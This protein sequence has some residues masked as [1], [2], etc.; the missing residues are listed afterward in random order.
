MSD[1]S[2]LSQAAVI[3]TRAR[4][5]SSKALPRA[6]AE[7]LPAQQEKTEGGDAGDAADGT[8]VLLDA[9]AAY[10]A[11]H[12]ATIPSVPSS[13]ARDTG[14]PTSSRP[15]APQALRPV[16]EQILAS[17]PQ[18]QLLATALGLVADCDWRLP[19]PLLVRV[20]NETAY[21]HEE[22]E[23]VLD[24]IDERAAAVLREHPVWGKRVEPLVSLPGGGSGDDSVWRL[25]TTA[26]RLAYFRRLRAQDPA[27]ART[28]MVTSWKK[29]KAEARE[30]IVEALTTGLGEADLPMLEMAI[31]DRSGGVRQAAAQVLLHLPESGLV[32]RAEALAASHMSVTKRFLRT[33]RVDCRPIE[34]TDEVLRDEYGERGTGDPSRVD[35]GPPAAR[36][37]AAGHPPALLEEVVGR[38][39]IDRWPALIGLSAGQLLEAEVTFEGKPLDLSSA[40]FTADR[41][42]SGA[43][44]EACTVDAFKRGDLDRFTDMRRFWPRPYSAEHSRRMVSF[45][46]SALGSHRPEDIGYWTTQETTRLPV[47]C[48]AAVLPEALALME[49]VSR[50][51]SAPAFVTDAVEG[52]RLRLRLEALRTP[53]S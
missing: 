49:E 3:G 24:V 29:E 10:G 33:P 34:V 48:H 44:I 21:R 36:K 11:V 16:L 38:V 45:L 19:A 30:G 42:E 43:L 28:L 53:P 2:R 5:F 32:Q 47:S 7:A 31:T 39:P 26:Q 13:A 35:V 52:L 22:R 1:L 9:A 17:K 6:V 40:L 14:W 18:Q 8:S 51:D 37:A 41:R 4:P 46:R 12:R 25:G 20:L 27:A 50:P 23:A 15:L